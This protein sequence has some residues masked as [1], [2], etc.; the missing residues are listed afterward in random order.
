MV[1]VW[2][3]FG[4]VLTPPISASM[5]TFCEKYGITVADL[6]G[7][8]RAVANR[9]GTDDAM[10]LIDT[11]IMTEQDWLVELADEV[12]DAFQL[13]TLA[14]VW[15]TDRAPNQTW[16]DHLRELRGLGVGIGM[17]SN[18]VPTWDGHWRRMLGGTDLFDHV[19]LSFEAGH[20][21]PDL[22]IYEYAAAAAGVAAADCVLV[23]DLPMNCA[24]AR[25]AGWGAV[26][27]TDTSSAIAA[28]QVLTSHN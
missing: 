22:G 4:G 9:H 12:N 16:I 17:L 18:M 24:G 27:F 14:D 15:F 25:A 19:V 13:E 5:S 26:E 23:D 28:L 21:K 6:R 11:G 20:R 10:A 2:T 7:A 8:L 1:Y 3:D